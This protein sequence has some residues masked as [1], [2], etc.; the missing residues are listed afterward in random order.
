MVPS[1]ELSK[2]PKNSSQDHISSHQ[3][4]SSYALSSK[5]KVHNSLLIFVTNFKNTII[6]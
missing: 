6:L 5:R 1:C 2:T 4:H 3:T